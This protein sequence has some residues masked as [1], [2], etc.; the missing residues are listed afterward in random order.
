MLTTA[1]VSD[2]IKA[3]LTNSMRRNEDSDEE[4]DTEDSQEVPD[5]KIRR[6]PWLVSLKKNYS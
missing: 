5:L 2:R 4:S 6:D 1:A 3:K